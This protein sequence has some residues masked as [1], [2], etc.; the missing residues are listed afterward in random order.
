MTKHLFTLLY[1]AGAV[2]AKTDALQFCIPAKDAE[3]AL[4]K[5]LKFGAGAV[6][7]KQE[8]LSKFW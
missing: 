8:L 5:S 4:E 2:T 1:P 3:E 6:V 7:V